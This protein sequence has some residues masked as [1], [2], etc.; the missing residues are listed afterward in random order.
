M[1]NRP[2][3]ISLAEK[4]FYKIANTEFEFFSGF[5]IQQK[6]RSIKSLHDAFLLSCPNNK[7][8]EVSR[9]SPLQIG[10]KLSAFNLKY[11][12]NGKYYPVECLFQGS[13]VFENGKVYQDLYERQPG[14]AKKDERLKNSGRIVGFKLDNT[15][16]ES[17]PKDFFYNWLY[18]NALNNDENIGKELLEYDSF[19]DI[20][21]NPKKSINCQAI[22]VAIYVGLVKSNNLEEALKSPEEFRKVVYGLDNTK[23]DYQ[24][25]NLFDFM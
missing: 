3:Y 9:K 22:A 15:D 20:E 1:A 6:Q 5:S 18:I 17:E 2:V 8:L 19:T 11:R 7:V 13:K 12:M 4:P 25:M 23:K 14:E 24:Q 10:N 21:F 16:F